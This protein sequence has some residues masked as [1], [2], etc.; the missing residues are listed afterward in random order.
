MNIEFI[1]E[2]NAFDNYGHFTHD[3]LV[4]LFSMLKEQNLLNSKNILYLNPKLYKW[5]FVLQHLDINIKYEKCNN[6]DIILNN[7]LNIFRKYELDK[8]PSFNW[9]FKYIEKIL[10]KNISLEIN[11]ACKVFL[12]T[13]NYKDDIADYYTKK[14][15]ININ[16]NSKNVLIIHRDPLKDRRCIIND[17]EFYNQ[18]KN[19]FDNI[20]YKVHIVNFSEMSF[21]EQITYI[22]KCSIIIG[23]FGAGFSN[24]LYSK[25]NPY[26]IEILPN[27][28]TYVSHYQWSNTENFKIMNI[29]K[30]NS[31]CTDRIK[32][33]YK[34]IGHGIY[35][36][37]RDQDSYVYLS[38]LKY[39]LDDITNKI[40]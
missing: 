37:S 26:V 9:S 36:E 6:P 15:K 1:N 35:P 12:R 21:E 31:I 23:Y 25:N 34:I 16:K 28:W 10:E 39:L 30:E 2:R 7:P 33:I 18:I 27:N 19:Y 11:N 14:L 13:E 17:T 40:K 24:T 20:G 3:N 4:H 5:N 8:R 22:N 29:K 32:R 38:D